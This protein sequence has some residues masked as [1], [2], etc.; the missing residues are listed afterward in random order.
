MMGARFLSSL[1]VLSFSVGGQ[2]YQYAGMGGM[3]RHAVMLR[4]SAITRMQSTSSDHVPTPKA[5][6]RPISRRAAVIAGGAALVG[7]SSVPRVVYAYNF[8]QQK[9]GDTIFDVPAVWKKTA[10]DAEAG[11]FAFADPV[12]GKVVD[13]ILVKEF[14]APEGVSGTKDLGKIE[15][16]NPSKAFGATKEVGN[17]LL[18]AGLR[19][20]KFKFLRAIIRARVQDNGRHAFGVHVRACMNADPAVSYSFPDPLR[21]CTLLQVATADMVAAAVRKGTESKTVFYDYDFA[22][23]PKECSRENEMLVGSCMYDKVEPAEQEQSLSVL[24]YV[25]GYCYVYFCHHP[26]WADVHLFPD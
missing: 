12:S 19:C 3:P 6:E 14:E 16:V 21:T 2:A 25:V 8:N 13:Q 22:K 26:G 1:L 24:E 7:V 5:E 4:T 11:T 18:R 15:K 10:E 23:A 17:S 9:S 20:L